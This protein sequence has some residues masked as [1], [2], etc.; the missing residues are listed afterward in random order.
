MD[1]NLKVDKLDSW[2][3]S[4]RNENESL[5]YNHLKLTEVVD[6]RDEFLPILQEIIDN[7]HDDYKRH[8]RSVLV[9]SLDPSVEIDFDRLG[10]SDP[11]YGYPSEL[12]LTTL[13]GYFGEI[14]AG[15][16][17]ENFSPFSINDWKVPVFCFRHHETAF[18]QL[19]TF[20]RTGMKKNA[21]I[22]RP[23]DDCVAFVLDNEKNEIVKT[24]FCEAKCT[25]DHDSS[26]INKAHSQISDLNPVPVELLRILEI[27]N[28]YDTEYAKKWA[29]A[30]STLYINNY[31]TE[32]F[33]LV[34]YVCGRAPV[35]SET[36]IDCN[37]PHKTYK[38]D[39]NLE[40]VEVHLSNVNE[41]VENLYWKEMTNVG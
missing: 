21:T 4:S 36:W 18:D 22:G 11:A 26:L 34:S 3:L 9:K 29:K 33:D 7:A 16:I 31:Q 24:L 39:R 32:R 6:L 14:F 12:N 38:G 15:I 1:I 13:K 19:E 17:A 20:K 37:K 10:K 35:N 40:C 8:K 23:G 5:K 28:D 41:L 30:I 27:L 25:N 2:L